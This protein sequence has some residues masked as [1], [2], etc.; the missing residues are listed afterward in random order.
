MRTYL[1]FPEG[2]NLLFVG[3]RCSSIVLI[4]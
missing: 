1:R 4:R 2:G 3:A